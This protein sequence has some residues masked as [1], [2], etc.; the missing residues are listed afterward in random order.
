MIQPLTDDGIGSL[1]AACDINGGVLERYVYDVFGQPQ[2]LGPDGVTP[3]AVSLLGLEPRFQGRPFITSCRLY[4]FRDRFYDPGLFIYL[5]PDPYPFW[6]AGVP[7]L[8]W[9]ITRSTIVTRMGAGY[10]SSSGR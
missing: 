8:S 2:V 6:M 7:T 10:T 5:Q 9:D 3:R 1:S 4:D